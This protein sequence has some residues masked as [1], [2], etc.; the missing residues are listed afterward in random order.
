MLGRELRKGLG[1]VDEPGVGMFEGSQEGRSVG[2]ELGSSDGMLVGTCESCVDGGTVRGRDGMAEGRRDGTADVGRSEGG[3]IDG[4]IDGMLALMTI[5]N[6]L[7]YA[8]SSSSLWRS[9]CMCV[10][11]SEDAS[12]LP[13][14]TPPLSPSSPTALDESLLTRLLLFCVGVP[15]TPTPSSKVSPSSEGSS[16]SLPP[17]ITERLRDSTPPSAS[18]VF[19]PPAQSVPP[20]SDSGIISD[21][22]GRSTADPLVPGSPAVGGGTKNPPGR[23]GGSILAAAAM[24]AAAAPRGSPC[25]PIR[26]RR[27]SD[28]PSGI[29]LMV[30]IP[31]AEAILRGLFMLYMTLFRTALRWDRHRR[32][33]AE[34]YL[35]YKKMPSGAD[36]SRKAG[37][38]AS[39]S[40]CSFPFSPS[41]ESY[42]IRG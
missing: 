29:T 3:G 28:D 25:P 13:P 8:L 18:V 35:D 5:M 32:R 9:S 11:P 31:R 6:R 36:R 14:S 26:I 37:M 27:S 24:A 20:P 40:R 17:G 41:I 38:G 39:N 42:Q 16:S 1:A 15:E 22:F 19:F 2:R 21:G 7:Q 33:D 30:I 10:P 12:A 4:C 23:D 34:N